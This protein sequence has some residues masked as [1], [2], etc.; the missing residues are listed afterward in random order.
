MSKNRIH[1]VW[2]ILLG[3]LVTGVLVASYILG[4]DKRKELHCNHIDI[5]IEDSL[6]LQ[7]LSSEDIRQ[8]ISADYGT[9]IGLQIDKIDLQKIE[10]I[11]NKK[12][13]IFNSEAFITNKGTLKVN[14][15]Q[16]KPIIRFQTRDYGFYCDQYGILFPLK[17]NFSCE[18]ILIDGHIPL[19]TDDCRN[20]APISPDDSLWLEETLRMVERINSSD[21]WKERIAQIHYDESGQI[22]IKPKEGDEEFLFGHLTDIDAKFEK[23][24]IYYE[25]I[26]PSKEEEAY[27]VV[28]LRY[29]KQIVCKKQ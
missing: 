28:D 14:I 8:H 23:M 7:Y 10:S 17:E 21:L 1:I 13:G 12:D 16:R 5:S 26:A 19:D 9:I 11:L 4:Y 25:M 24:K 2:K 15:Q 20:G 3:L 6:W 29:R 27:N 18:A 22:S